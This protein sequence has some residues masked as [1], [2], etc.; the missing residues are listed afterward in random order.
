M[1][2]VSFML[3]HV[4][5]SKSGGNTLNKQSQIATQHLLRDMLHEKCC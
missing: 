1:L 5:K 4:A 3:F 2:F